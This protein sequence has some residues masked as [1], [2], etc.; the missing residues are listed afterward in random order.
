MD[1]VSFDNMK[2]ESIK[3]RT[4]EGDIN[5]VSDLEDDVEK[6][7][8]AYNLA[9]SGRGTFLQNLKKLNQPQMNI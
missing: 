5:R 2:A 8:N 4:I 1:A 3:C 6:Y 9:S 7:R